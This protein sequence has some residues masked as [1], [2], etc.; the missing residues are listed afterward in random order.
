MQ[1]KSSNK[2]F[3]IVFF[4]FFL[5]LGLWPLSSGGKI[6][7]F[8]MITSFLF[9]FLGLTNSKFLTVPNKIWIK[10]GIIMGSFVSPIVLLIF[11]STI[12]LPMGI[13]IKIF[14]KDILRLKIEKNPEHSYWIDKED[15]SDIKDQF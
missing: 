6:S 8:L 2:S 1:N 4:L 11:Y 10:F 14:K 12:F 9:L 7:I 3:G 5:I 15:K 13:L